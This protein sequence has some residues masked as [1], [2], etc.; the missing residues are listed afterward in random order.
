MT[1][2][3]V[4]NQAETSQLVISPGQRVDKIIWIAAATTTLLVT[5]WILIAGQIV[6]PRK[7]Q[8]GLIAAYQNIRGESEGELIY[9]FKRP[10]SAEFY[11]KG[12]AL[13]VDKAE[14]IN[15]YFQNTTEDYFSIKKSYFKRLPESVLQRVAKLGEYNGYYL[16]RE[17]PRYD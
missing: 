12:Q 1:E 16:L 15:I 10:H 6:P 14:D 13:L 9:L 7:C 3:M 2:L 4:S 17:K 8:K 5:A 11:S